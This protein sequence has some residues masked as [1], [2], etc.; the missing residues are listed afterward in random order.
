MSI[1]FKS[2]SVKFKTSNFV[3]LIK[4]KVKVKVKVKVKEKVKLK[5]KEM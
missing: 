1:T 2:H 4:A 5:V 3:P